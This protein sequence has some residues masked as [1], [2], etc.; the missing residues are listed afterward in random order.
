MADI[1]SL[2]SKNITFILSSIV[3][4]GVLI[5]TIQVS[6]AN[7]QSLSNEVAAYNIRVQTLE[8]CVVHLVSIEQDINEMKTDIKEIR[9]TVFRPAR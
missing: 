9:T 4:L 2:V 7:I 3:A 6:A 5:A 1:N 8:K